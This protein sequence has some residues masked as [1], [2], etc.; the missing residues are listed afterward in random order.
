M[1]INPDHFRITARWI[2]PVSSPPLENGVVEVKA[3]RITAVHSSAVSDAVDLG[4]VAL[5]PALINTHT[6]LEF[7]DLPQ[8]VQPALPFTA[9][10]SSLVAARRSRPTTRDILQLGLSECAAT[11]T[12]AVG[13]IATQ[14]WSD[15]DYGRESLQVTV[16]R[17]LIGPLPDRI[18]GQLEIARNWLTQSN[19]SDAH[20]T[21]GL[22][23]HA[24]YTVHP[25]LYRDLIQLAADHNAPL[26]IHLAESTAELELLK[27][28]QG[29]FVEMLQR[30]NAWDPQAIPKGTRPIDYLMPLGNVPRALVVHGN[31]LQ[32]EDFD[33][34]AEM[35]HVSVVY[36]PRTHHFFQHSPHPWQQ[37]LNRGINVALGTDGRGS[38]PDLSLWNEMR[39][40]FEQNPQ[41]DP[42]AILKLG[43]IAGAKAMGLDADYGTLEPGKMAAMALV[44]LPQQSCGDAYRDLFAAQSARRLNLTQQDGTVL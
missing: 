2:F 44:P 38:N 37:M 32:A 28:G 9:W 12:I 8:P 17:E 4:N 24:P 23:P 27:S 34:L 13:E 40:L 15:S 18:A 29:E 6:H 41:V 43:T 42:A 26:A 35:P 3:G 19:P 31:Y 33:C 1:N 22:S 5:I 10:L 25:D 36:C 16:F 21:R 7:S 11:G 39:F 30:F 20:V 14:D